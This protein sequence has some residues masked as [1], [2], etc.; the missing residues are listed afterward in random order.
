MTEPDIKVPRHDFW[1]TVVRALIGRCPNCGEGKLFASY[2]KPV[3]QCAVCGERFGHI[4]A[5]DGPA[6]LTILIVGHMLAP[7][8]LTVVPGSS[9]PEWV[10]M[11]VWPG[12]ALIMGLLILPRAKGL[13]IG[14]IWRSNC[15][16][17]EKI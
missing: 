13:F 10:S 9:W 3:E 4:R 14:I 6:W 2:L 17:A 7:I 12:F 16:G 5:D 1:L 11:V 8:L 15:V